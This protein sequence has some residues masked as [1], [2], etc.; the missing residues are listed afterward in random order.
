MPLIKPKLRQ[1]KTPIK[2]NISSD[3]LDEIKFYYVYSDTEQME[4]Y[5]GFFE[6]AA[7][8]ILKKDTGFKKWKKSHHKK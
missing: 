1:E 3:L 6:Q 8:Y 2:I 7:L 4:T 5:E